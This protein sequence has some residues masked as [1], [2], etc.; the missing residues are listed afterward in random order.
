MLV[1]IHTTRAKGKSTALRHYDR[2]RLVNREGEPL[3][4]GDL[5]RDETYVFHYPFH[6]TPC[7]LINLGHTAAHHS[8]LETE[9]GRHYEWSGG[10]GPRGTVVAYSAICAH[11]MTYPAR[12]VSFINYY[13]K[14]KSFAD[15]QHIPVRRANVIYCCSEKSVY[16]AAHG[17][18]VLGGPAPQPLA[19][20]YLEYDAIEDQFYAT[21]TLGGEMFDKFFEEFGYRLALEYGTDDIRRKV[22]EVAPVLRLAEYCDNLVQC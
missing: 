11:M 9:D 6:A 12:K 2:V 17:A 15:G 3:H 18:K 21:G 7:F 10:V 14:V 4:S 22:K 16:D 20:I 19:V 5:W 13:G 8:E 1:G